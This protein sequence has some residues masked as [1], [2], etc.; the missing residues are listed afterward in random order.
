MDVYGI[1]E[2]V[3]TLLLGPHG[4]VRTL[5]LDPHGEVRTLLLGPYGDIF[6]V[7]KNICTEKAL[8]FMTGGRKEELK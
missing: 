7:V 1:E 4:E 6:Q 5:L 2:E 8:W 3:R